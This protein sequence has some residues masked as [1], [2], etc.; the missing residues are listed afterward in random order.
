MLEA[1]RTTKESDKYTKLEDAMSCVDLALMRLSNAYTHQLAIHEML[2]F[3]GESMS[4][5]CDTIKEAQD[6]ITAEPICNAT[7]GPNSYAPVA[8][9]HTSRIPNPA[10]KVSLS[11]GKAF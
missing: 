11:R 9:A 4:T 3:I 8:S 7:N 1:F 10:N 6:A 2:E 5:A